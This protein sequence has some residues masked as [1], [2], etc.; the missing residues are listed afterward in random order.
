MTSCTITSAP[1]KVLVTGGYLVLEQAF[2]GCVVSTSS[3]FYTIIQAQSKPNHISVHSP[4]FEQADWTYVVTDDFK[5]KANPG[6][7]Q[8]VCG[9]RLE[10][11]ASVDG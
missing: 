6:Q 9:D 1:G 2:W 5:L 10:L 4:Q 3:R 7:Y 8:Q 11:H